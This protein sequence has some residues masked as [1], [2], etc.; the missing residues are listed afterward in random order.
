MNDWDKQVSE[1]AEKYTAEVFMLLSG[2][3]EKGS[4]N[5]G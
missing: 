1:A 4:P 2:L 5:G 3:K